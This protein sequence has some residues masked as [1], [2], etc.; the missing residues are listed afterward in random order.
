M[1]TSCSNCGFPYKQGIRCSLCGS[2]GSWYP[3]ELLSVGGTVFCLSVLFL[4]TMSMIGSQ[5]AYQQEIAH[6][7]ATM[8]AVPTVTAQAIAAA[9]ATQQ[10]IPTITAQAIAAA[11][12]TQQ[13]IV[14]GQTATQQA[15][16]TATTI[17]KLTATAEAQ[18]IRIAQ[19]ASQQAVEEARIAQ[20]TATDEARVAA[21]SNAQDAATRQSRQDA[22]R[23]A[24]QA[25]TQEAQRTATARVGAE[26]QQATT[27]ARNADQ[28]SIENVVIRYGKDIKVENTTN[29]DSS[30]LSDVLVDPVLEKQERS[31]CWLQNEGF[32][33]TYSNRSFTIEELTFDAQ[34]ATVLA[35]I[36]EN[37]ILHK[38]DGTVHRNYGYEDY[39]AIYELEKRS[40][41]RWYIY[42]FQALIGDTENRCEVNIEGSD[43]CQ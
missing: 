38:A 8:Q 42:C 22:T 14:A 18:A 11:T 29:L 35:N 12:A 41:G 37:R 21:T 33:Y 31:A 25:A 1:N 24:N 4:C 15:A 26:R 5:I 13:T 32:Y 23:R 2:I 6:Q 34:K 27:R 28:A 19:T 16:R 36:R 40:N 17:S 3:I 30:N 10:A 9:T 39:R 20:V 43:P 7:T